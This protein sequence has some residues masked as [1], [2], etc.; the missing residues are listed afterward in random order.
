MHE[1]ITPLIAANCRIVVDHFGRPDPVLGLQ[2]PGFAYLLSPA[3]YNRLWVKL[4][5]PYRLW[6]VENTAAQDREATRQLLSAFPATRL[7]WG[8]DWPHTEHR[9]EANYLSA[10]NALHEWVA[11]A[12]VRHTILA[13][14]P[15]ALLGIEG[16]TA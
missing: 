3:R 2:D 16:D 13:D 5:A 10:H 12:A 1:A 4:S 11:D 14:T 9:D 6:P 15:S 7:M 8:S